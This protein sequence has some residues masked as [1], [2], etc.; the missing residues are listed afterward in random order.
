MMAG[1]AAIEQAGGN[2]SLLRA[3]GDRRDDLRRC[4]RTRIRRSAASLPVCPASP[5][6]PH[7]NRS[8]HGGGAVRQPDLHHAAGRHQSIPTPSSTTSWRTSTAPAASRAPPAFPSSPTPEPLVLRANAGDCVTVTLYNFRH[9]GQPAGG[10]LGSQPAGAGADEPA[11]LRPDLRLEQAG[12]L[13]AV[14][15]LL[16]R[17]ACIRSSP[18]STPRRA[19]ASTSA[20]TRSRRRRSAA[21]VT[22]TWY[23][24]N[25][26]VRNPVNPYIPI[27]LGASN[28]LPADVVNH[29]Q[30][31][32]FGALVI[33]PEGA[34]GW[35]AADGVEAHV[36]PASG[37]AFHEF[38]LATQDGLAN[39]P[40]PAG[41]LGAAAL[42]AVNYKTMLPSFS[43]ISLRHRGRRL[44]PLL[45]LRAVLLDGADEGRL[46][47]RQ[48]GAL[49][50]GPRAVAHRLRRRAGALPPAASGRRHHQRGL[51]ALR[52]RLDR[53]ALRERR[54]SA[55]RRRPPTPT[56]TPRRSSRTSGAAR[57]GSARR[58]PRSALA[59]VPTAAAFLASYAQHGGTR[60][61]SG[62]ARA[63]ATARATT[64][65]S[66]S[67]RRAAPTPSPA[68]TSS[69]P[70]RRTSST[71]ASGASSGSGAANRRRGDVPQPCCRCAPF[72]RSPA[73]AGPGGRA[74]PNP[75]RREGDRR[76]ALGRA[77]AEEGQEA[78]IR[79]RLSDEATGTPLAGA[80]P[81]AW[82][83]ATARGPAPPPPA[84]RRWSS[85][86]AAASSAVRPST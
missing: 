69:A 33:E 25:V 27:E 51:R 41:T 30:H 75:R 35:Q 10:R 70:I 72:S 28:L 23:A 1:A 49:Q 67:R 16:R 85:S 76:R 5:R 17:W 45:R 44:V 59:A 6:P 36:Q 39:P 43:G 84:P 63:A 2:W 79:F 64:S 8:L 18:P 31:G 42:N 26:D 68:T 86:S 77:R 22:Y 48:L 58:R 62:R 53:D 21:H 11:D 74:P 60:S 38:V 56:S 46:P 32:L 81:A 73:P 3:Y 80:S 19:T 40:S 57:P 55:A 66:S 29:Y 83:D 82:L 78:V 4:P 13:P 12:A 47:Q 52:P 61:A 9:R 20:P 54:R 15:H 7:Q 50:P 34:T 37:P 14:E 65:T 24:G 71:S